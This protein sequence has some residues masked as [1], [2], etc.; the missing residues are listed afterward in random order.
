MS[1][2]FSKIGVIFRRYPLTRGVMTYTITWPIANLCQQA[3]AGKEK[4]DFAEAFRYSVFGALYVAPTLHGWIKLTGVLWPQMNLKVAV[5][6]V[7]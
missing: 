3:I 6:K 4:F 2:V 1:P 5:T 7:K